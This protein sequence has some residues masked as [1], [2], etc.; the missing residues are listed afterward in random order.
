MPEASDQTGMETGRVRLTRAARHRQLVDVS[1]RIVRE[2]GTDALTLGRLAE[3]AGVTKPVVYDQFRSR[4]G[5]L[6]TLYREFD[7]RQTAVIDAALAV[8]GPALESKAEVVATSYIDCVLLQGREIPDVIA[9]L[10]GS[11]ELETIKR[12]YHLAFIEKCRSIFAP[13]AESGAIP[14][15]GLWAMLGAAEAVSHAAAI[16]D[17]TPE[18]AANELA[19]VIVAMVN[20]A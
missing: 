3:L 9:A 1:W 7:D 4:N 12:D 17:L 15:A 19:Q 2:Q 13:F 10:S 20:R 6:A 8:S 11:A 5:L 16:G 18:Q 14:A